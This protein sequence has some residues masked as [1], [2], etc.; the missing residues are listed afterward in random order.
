VTAT[1][2][3][4]VT[5]RDATATPRAVVVTR[6]TDYE[7]LL[8]RHGTREAARFF[9]ESRGQSIDDAEAR[10][11]R[12]EA[13]LNTVLQGIPVQ[14]RRNRVDREDLSRFV[15]EPGDVIVAVGQDGLVANAA[16][17]LDGQRVIGV[18]P[19][20]QRFD[21]V[22]A[23]HRAGRAGKLLR[24]TAEGHVEIEARTMVEATLDDGQ[25]LLA[26]NEV[27]VGH[28]THQSARYRL[29]HAGRE[30]RHSS[31]GMVV[32]TGTGAT[33][34]ARSIHL[35]RHADLALP[36]P[37]D[38]RL[39]FFVREAFP[40]VATG[41]SLVEGVLGGAE[42]LEV[43][44]EMNDGGTVFG[45]GIESDRIDFGWGLRARVRVA[46]ERLQLVR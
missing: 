1:P 40:S 2:C 45:D 36:A 12:F 46:R 26:L 17:Y 15:F 37:S 27:F 8:A 23:L 38:P 34:W 6:A 11:R 10:H 18:N 29:R 16:K 35:A 13:A 30:E 20:P 14:W 31:S 22:L 39:A 19:D 5:A 43:T 21:G 24:A 4:G 25:R 3:A 33:G 44:S 28:R 41:T 42:V 9:L 32:S 7:A